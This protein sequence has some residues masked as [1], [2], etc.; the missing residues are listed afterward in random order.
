MVRYLRLYAYCARFSI[1]RAMEFRWDFAFRVFFDLVWAV[2]G[3]LFFL[4]LYRHTGLIGGWTLDQTFVFIGAYLL[5]DA[6]YMTAFSENLFELPK[7]INRGDLDYHVVRPVSSLFL[8]S[9]R[10][11]SVTTLVHL[12]TSSAFLTWALSVYPEPLAAIDVAT[13]FGLLLIGVF[14]FWEINVLFVVPVFWTH[15]DSGMKS[16]L[17]PLWETAHRPHQV[18]TGWFRRLITLFVPFALT[19]SVPVHVLFGGLTSAT[20][21][22]MTG[23][24]TVL[25]GGVILAWRMGLRAYTSASS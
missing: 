19:A 15:N 5:V 20:A 21:L 22:L 14:V 13:F 2:T 11:L 8:L 17:F 1:S 25:F 4:V 12:A 10:E 16:V 23:V 24:P 9:V 7:L 18:F 3:V 6:I